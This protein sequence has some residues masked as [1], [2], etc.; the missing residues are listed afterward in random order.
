[1][2]AE[3][4]T[5]M[6]NE[7]LRLWRPNGSPT[8]RPANIAL[9]SQRTIGLTVYVGHVTSRDAALK[10]PA[11]VR[12]PVERVAVMLAE[13]QADREQARRTRAFKSAA[14]TWSTCRGR[15]MS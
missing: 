3:R 13:R 15:V 10:Y 5:A 4:S 8:R 2:D 7:N 9:C 12:S 14:A 6:G 1:M 11:L